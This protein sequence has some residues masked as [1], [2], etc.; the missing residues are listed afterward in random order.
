VAHKEIIIPN[1]PGENGAASF[2]SSAL[3]NLNARGESDAEVC[4]LSFSLQ[5]FCISG[6]SRTP[7][8]TLWRRDAFRDAG[9]RERERLKR[10]ERKCVNTFIS[11]SKTYALNYFLRCTCCT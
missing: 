11:I 3:L 5:R 4:A 10:Q 7:Q 9:V 2:L 1:T 6:T 8:K